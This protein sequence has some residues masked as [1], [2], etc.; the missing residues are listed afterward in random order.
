MPVRP[1]DAEQADQ[2]AA[3]DVDQV[4][5]QQVR[6]DVRHA[7]LAAEE[8]DVRG[9]RPVAEGVVEADHV[10]VGVAA[11]GGQEADARLSASRSGRARSR[12]A[13]GFP[14]PS[15]SLRRRTQQP[16]SSLA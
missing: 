8:A 11:G 5:R 4:L 12:R 3:A 9:P 1:P 16:V 13:A 7:P 6:A 2:A 14:T 15:R 10:V